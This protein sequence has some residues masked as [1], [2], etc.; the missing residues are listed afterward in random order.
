M[1]GAVSREF[2]GVAGGS[3]QRGVAGS[4][5]YRGDGDAGDPDP[6]AA[7][8]ASP[9]R[10]K[11][12]PAWPRFRLLPQPQAGGSPNLLRP[13]VQIT[14][15]SE[16][17]AKATVSAA[18]ASTG[19]RSHPGP[20]C[21][22]RRASAK[23]WF[24]INRTSGSA[25]RGVLSI[26]PEEEQHMQGA[27]NQG[28][29]KEQEPGS[30]TG[31]YREFL[32]AVGGWRRPFQKPAVADCGRGDR[33]PLI[34]TQNGEPDCRFVAVLRLGEWRRVVEKIIL[35][36]LGLVIALHGWA[37][38]ALGARNSIRRHALYSPSAASLANWARL[39]RTAPA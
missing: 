37:A 5:N 19:L 23:S 27:R 21:T 9:K 14:T 29:P 10:P 7:C 16:Q 25:S 36:V 26:H 4:R 34:T 32:V 15:V 18:P 12:L 28:Q 8:G 20:G 24:S 35:A 11:G 31:F 33:P 17:H 38:P 13:L 30:R 22:P 39:G 3:R 1:Q 2:T 6:Y